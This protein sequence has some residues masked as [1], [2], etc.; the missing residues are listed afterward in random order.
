MHAHYTGFNTESYTELKKK[1]KKNSQAIL[2]VRVELR[3]N[4][5]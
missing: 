4:L 3:K 5:L 1:Q 2:V